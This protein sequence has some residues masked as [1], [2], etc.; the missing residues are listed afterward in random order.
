MPESTERGIR[1]PLGIES[2]DWPGD[3]E[4]MANDIDGLM[5]RFAGGVTRITPTANS[6]TKGTVQFPEGLFTEAPNMLATAHSKVVGGTLTGL[7]VG[8]TADVSRTS[9]DIFMYR[10]NNTP[11]TVTWVAWQNGGGVSAQGWR[12]P[13]YAGSSGT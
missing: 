3:F 12:H 7:S 8:T 11:T 9:G 10:G 5:P 2:P 4:R 13:Q 6:V 1:Y